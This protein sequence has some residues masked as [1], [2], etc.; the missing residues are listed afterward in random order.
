MPLIDVVFLLITFFI[1]AMTLMIRA[2]VLPIELPPLSAGREAPRVDAISVTLDPAGSLFVDGE[3]SS[4]ELVV[5][6][7][8]ERRAEKPD[9]RIYIAASLEGDADRLPTFIE[10]VNRLRGSGIEEFF[11][12]GRPERE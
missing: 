9:A 5:D 8:H 2:Q 12:V 11:I 6:E 3:Q 1:F 7:I 10:L 4:L